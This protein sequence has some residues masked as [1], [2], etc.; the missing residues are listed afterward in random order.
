MDVVLFEDEK[1]FKN[2]WKKVSNS[3][4]KEFNTKPIYNKKTLKIKTK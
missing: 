4:K 2:I 1:L 3:M